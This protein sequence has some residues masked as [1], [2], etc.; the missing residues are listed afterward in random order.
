LRGE[1]A[2]GNKG[3]FDTSDIFRGER[4]RISPALTFYPSEF[5]KLRLQYNYDHGHRIQRD[6]VIRSLSV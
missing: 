5:S 1:Y 6:W 2:D 3:A 4:T